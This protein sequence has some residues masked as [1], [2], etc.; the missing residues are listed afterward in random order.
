M[1][2]LIFSQQPGSRERHLMRK[3]ANPLFPEGARLISSEQLLEAQRLDHEELVNFITRFKTLIH[4]VVNLPPN[5]ESE[6]ILAIKEQLDQAYEQ[7]SGLAD[8][9]QET[10]Q[11][12]EK[13]TAVIMQAIRKGAENDGVALQELEQETRARQAHYEL[14]HSPLVADIL[15]PDSPIQEGELV[16]VLLSATEQEFTAALALFD[17]DQRGILARQA[18]ALMEVTA[19]VPTAIKARLAALLE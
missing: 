14:L 15:N 16:P 5:A 6:T 9:Q 19:D 4:Q 2:Q 8:D 1:M 10:K 17:P 3:Q 12:V 11:A 7:A 18:Q 13:L